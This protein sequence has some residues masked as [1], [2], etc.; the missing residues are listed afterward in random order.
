MKI[1]QDK[2][3]TA[4]FWIHYLKIVTL[5]CRFLEIEITYSWAMHLNPVLPIILYFV[6]KCVTF[7]MSLA[8]HIYVQYMCSTSNKMAKVEFDRYS[9]GFTSQ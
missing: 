1:I 7:T 6:A 5:P 2:L 4:K 8:S 3:T 9:A